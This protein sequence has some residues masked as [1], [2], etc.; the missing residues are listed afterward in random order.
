MLKLISEILKTIRDCLQL[1]KEILETKKF[2]AIKQQTDRNINE[3]NK[4]ITEG[5]TTDLSA[6]FDSLRKAADEAAGNN[7]RS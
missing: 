1:Y 6:K 3:T 4:A 7:P 5:N 2:E